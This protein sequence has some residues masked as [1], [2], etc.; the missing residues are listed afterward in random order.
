MVVEVAEVA[1]LPLFK[2]ISGDQVAV[3]LDR[4]YRRSFDPG[5]II[6]HQGELSHDMYIIL[7]GLVEVD[8][9]IGALGPR[10]GR[11]A[12]EAGEF[13]G[14]MALLE[15]KERSATVTALEDTECLV[16]SRPE[17]EELLREYPSLTLAILTTM[18]RRLRA[19][20]G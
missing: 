7:K 6:I 2:D 4:G 12:L 18:S 16:L 19:I 5:E 1:H 14:E 13:F 15:G 9:R 17:L 8:R 20:G 3:V 11:L 10:F